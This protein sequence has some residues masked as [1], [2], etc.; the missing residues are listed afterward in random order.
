MRSVS[1]LEERINEAKS[2]GFKSVI[3]PMAN[4]KRMKNSP[5][6]IKICGV[7]NVGEAFHNLF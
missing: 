5:K 4:V 7:S 6:G 3:A 1:R 2:L